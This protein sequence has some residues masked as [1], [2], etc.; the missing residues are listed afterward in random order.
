MLYNKYKSNY[1]TLKKMSKEYITFGTSFLYNNI[2]NKIKT[3]YKKENSESHVLTPSL[4][5][6]DGE[7][8]SKDSELNLNPKKSKIKAIKN[9]NSYLS[10]IN[11]NIKRREKLFNDL[12]IFLRN[13]LEEERKEKLQILRDSEIVKNTKQQCKRMV[14][15]IL[16]NML[17]DEENGESIEL[18]TK[19]E[20][21]NFY[22]N[23]KNYVDE[24][25]NI[26]FHII[27]HSDSVIDVKGSKSKKELS[28][29]TPKISKKSFANSFKISSED[30]ERINWEN[31]I[32][33]QNSEKSIF[34]NSK[35]SKPFF[36]SIDK[37]VLKIN[38]KII[39]G[40]YR[41]K[42]LKSIILK[43]EPLN[44]KENLDVTKLKTTEVPVEHVGCPETSPVNNVL[45]YRKNINKIHSKNGNKSTIVKVPTSEKQQNKLK[46]SRDSILI[47]VP[48][49][50]FHRLTVE[51]LS[52]KKWSKIFEKIAKIVPLSKR[53]Q[54]FIIVLLPDA[55]YSNEDY[56]NDDFNEAFQTSVS[57]LILQEEILDDFSFN[58]I[59]ETP[60]VIV[61]P[62][63]SKHTLVKIDAEEARIPIVQMNSEYPFNTSSKQNNLSGNLIEDINCTDYNTPEN[64][65]VENL[66]G[67]IT[68]RSS[69]FEVGAKKRAKITKPLD[70]LAASLK[71]D[72]TGLPPLKIEIERNARRRQRY[73]DEK[74][75]K[76]STERRTYGE[77]LTELCNGDWLWLSLKK[78]LKKRSKTV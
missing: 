17:M 36:L 64:L 58:Y 45:N 34:L 37:N 66:G 21:G 70:P 16:L 47:T 76:I 48:T 61:V 7:E 4:E 67:I 1:K 51:D 68:G 54:P 59:S 77:K 60:K 32:P 29:L 41:N 73:K 63:K 20:N 62:S 38:S 65:I 52:Q 71:F 74:E 50:D 23:G 18:I 15:N 25:R 2:R 56:D 78:D 46:I 53:K 42:D 30:S 55:N 10:K 31:S 11:L 5:F 40:K 35:S 8:L 22:E 14:K 24:Q 19:G 49:L 44:S 13:L 75:S 12:I 9:I 39:F 33:Y 26:N 28:K 72:S 27:R 69:D 6:L 3:K 43:I 57:Q